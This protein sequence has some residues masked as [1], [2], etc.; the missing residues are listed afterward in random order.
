MNKSF[1]KKIGLTFAG[2]GLAF[3]LAACGG[4]DDGDTTDG[5]TADDGGDDAAAGEVEL[6]LWAWPGFGLQDLA[7]EYEENNPGITINIQE[8]DYGDVHQNLITAL[9]AGSGAPD[10][11]AVDEGYLDRMKENSQHFYNLYDFGAADL[12]D[13]Y[14]DWKWQQA[15]NV[16]G[17][18]MIGIP[19]DVGPMVMA[20]RMDLFEEAGLP[21]DPDEVAELMSTWEDYIEVGKQLN[22]A[23]GVKMF[24]TIS[25][26][27][28]AILEQGEIQY[29]DEDGNFVGD[30]S[31]QNKKAWDL[32]V[33]AKDISMNINRHT[34]EWGAA[35]AAGD[36]ATVF[37][38]PWML[39]NIKNDAPDTAGQ[40]NITF[41]PEGS[42]NFGGSFLT[43]PKQGEN[44]EAAYDFITWVMAPEQQLQ[45]FENSG[46]F[47]STPAVYDEPSIQELSDEFFT[48]PDLG[49]I[50]AEAAE[51]I[52]AGIKGPMHDPISQLM[53][54]AL[55]TVEDGTDPDQA[56][57][58]AVDEAKRQIAR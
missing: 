38:P 21:T 40:W 23:T 42:G 56:W 14:L 50:Y 27:Y 36:F 53:Q 37:L 2:L 29:F 9:A 17:D 25:D 18:F 55:G 19:T 4:D 28:L 22:D 26:L 43:L 10:I 58:S 45:I 13:N 11:S 1:A 15:N 32:A 48:R 46:P 20:Y 6:T 30:V 24:N 33:S 49:A 8:A 47:P 57:E 7:S 44:A 54:D 31:E 41:M 12:Q 51:Q 52:V 34:T 39:Q 35:L 5:D 16:E 3:G